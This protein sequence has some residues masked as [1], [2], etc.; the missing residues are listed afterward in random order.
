MSGRGRSRRN[1][2]LE[3]PDLD[4]NASI[5]QLLR[6]LVEQSGRANGQYSS[7][8]GPSHDDPQDKF[9][10]QKPKEFSGTTDP[11]VAAI[12]IKSMKVIFEYLQ[13]PDLDRPRCTIYM[14]RDDAMIWWM[15]PSYLWIWQI[16]LGEISIE[17]SSRNT[18]QQ[19]RGKWVYL[20]TLVMSLF[21]LQDVCIAIGSLATLD[22]PMVVDLIGIYVLKGPY[23]HHKNYTTKTLASYLGRPLLSPPHAAT[24]TTVRRLAPPC[25]RRDQT[26]SDRL[27]K[28]NLIVLKSV[29]SSSAD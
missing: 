5:T 22:L 9:R 23:W 16:L 19:T 2:S 13:M 18:S 8:R 27:D 7:S 11:L 14:L 6:L 12:W 1:A 25:R 3:E 26:C 15:D 21:D 20:V 17:Y 24:D 10:R 29:K 4:S 28:E